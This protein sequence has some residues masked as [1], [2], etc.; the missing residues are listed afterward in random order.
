M[1]KKTTA[2]RKPVKRAKKVRETKLAKTKVP[3]TAKTKLGAGN[4]LDS[5]KAVF[6]T[7]APLIPTIARLI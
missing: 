2:Q 5:L 1:P 6:S 4:F 3:K 7:V